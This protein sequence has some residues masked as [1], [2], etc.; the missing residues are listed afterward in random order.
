MSSCNNRM[1]Y[2]L[3]KPNSALADLKKSFGTD[4]KISNLLS[5]FP[6]KIV[7]TTKF[8][9]FSAPPSCLPSYECSAQFGEIYLIHKRDSVTEIELKNKS[10][11]STSYLNDSIIII[12]Q[13]ELRR[14]M[15][16]VAKC[17]KSFP[18]R[19]PVPYFESYDFGLG[20]KCYEKIIDGEKYYNNVY[21]I[22]NDLFIYVLEAKAGDFWKVSCNEK[23]P[24]SLQEWTHGYSKGITISKELDIIIY[25]TMV[26]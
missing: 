16:P 9:M 5:H 10:I 24:E 14:D 17:N 26:W 3:E 20:D 23:R 2:M 22:P 15:F 18:D 4:Y 19:L 8:R 25:W 11:Y 13:T 12:N 1:E 7:D 6:D 21:S